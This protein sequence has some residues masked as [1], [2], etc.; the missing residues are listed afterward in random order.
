VGDEVLRDGGREG[1]TEGH[2]FIRILLRQMGIGMGICTSLPPSRPTSGATY[3][4]PSKKTAWRCVTAK[5]CV[6]QGLLNPTGMTA[7]SV[8]SEGGMRRHQK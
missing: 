5:S 4:A 6:M 3:N 1:G 7:S 2:A 8:P